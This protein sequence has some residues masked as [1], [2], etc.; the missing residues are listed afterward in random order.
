MAGWAL[1]HDR[2][3]RLWFA[4]LQGGTAARLRALHPGIPAALEGVAFVEEGRLH[5]RGRA[6]LLAARHLP[7]PWRWA[8][9]LARLPAWL[10]DPPY[11]L[12]AR[13]RH[14]VWGR[15]DGC[16]LPDAPDPGR[17]LP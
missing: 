1:R 15:F 9:P 17:L 11:R 12:V 14:R 3:R 5:L 4:P 13:V 6:L 8:A 2:E 10:L 7:A 16:R